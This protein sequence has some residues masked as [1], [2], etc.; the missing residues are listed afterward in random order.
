ME[1]PDNSAV[2]GEWADWLDAMGKAPRTV[3]LYVGIVHRLLGR[4][5]TRGKHL[6]DL[7]PGELITHVSDIGKHGP[8]KKQARVALRSLY[9]YVGRRGWRDDDPSL[10][11][12]GSTQKVRRVR[13]VPFTDSE[14]DQLVAA[15]R[16]RDPRRA[17]AILACHGLGTRRT[18][19]VMIRLEDV[20]FTARTVHLAVTKGDK[21]R[22]VHMGPTAERALRALVSM[23]PNPRGTVDGTLLGISPA[24]FTNW[25]HDAAASCGFPKGRKR[26]AHTLRTTFA[27]RLG[28]A[29]IPGPVIRDMMG[30]ESIETTNDYLGTYEGDEE[31]AAQVI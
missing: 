31:R 6:F 26:R 10:I 22:D 16:R 27:S 7:G 17:W 1:R 15:A 21:P 2:I 30:H 25:V 3:E 11:L 28:R 24:T 4:K 19:F 12:E 20:S 13:P 9:G 5:Y 14:F 8:A 18:E 23:G 29:G